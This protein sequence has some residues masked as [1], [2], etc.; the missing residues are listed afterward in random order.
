M[1]STKENSCHIVSSKEAE[2]MKYYKGFIGL[3]LEQ[4][5]GTTEKAIRFT[6]AS[7]YTGLNDTNLWIPKAVLKIGD[8]NEY[9]NAPVY[10][11]I[12]FV[13][14]RGIWKQIKMIRE[15]D[16]DEIVEM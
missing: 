2:D 8:A 13:A 6:V 15:V 9:G 4:Y 5:H 12:W 7:G 16:F 3:P 14:K 11:P 1:I 10:L